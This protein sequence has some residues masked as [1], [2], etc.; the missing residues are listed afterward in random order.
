MPLKTSINLAFL[1]LLN[2][3]QELG[4][5]TLW[6]LFLSIPATITSALTHWTLTNGDYIRVVLI[7]II[8]DHALGTVVHLIK[9][10]FSILKNITG[11]ALKLFIIICMGLLFESLGTLVK[12]QS[13]IYTYLITVLHI[14]VFLYPAKSAM[15]N[16]H[17]LTKGVFPPR[18]VV[19]T[20]S[21]FTDTFDI[22]DLDFNPKE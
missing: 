19:K 4:S 12:A 1:Y 21:K 8:I 9:R 5:A 20:V 13:F 3:A 17:I 16:S 15:L 2:N 6:A 22:R 14:G 7:G 11:L 18:I 10:D